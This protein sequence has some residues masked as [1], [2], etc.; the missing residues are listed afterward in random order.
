M[1]GLRNGGTD[2]KILTRESHGITILDLRGKSTFDNNGSEALRAELRRLSDNGVNNLLLNVEKLTQI[3]SS[4]IGVVVRAYVSLRRKGGSLKLLRPRDRVKMV[5]NV[6]HLLDTI[7]N[8]EDEGKAL[9]SF[10]VES[11]IG[12]WVIG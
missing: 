6:F 9:A 7:P 12:P 2:L 3:D 5:L 1:F 10:G 11:N 8:F 4:C